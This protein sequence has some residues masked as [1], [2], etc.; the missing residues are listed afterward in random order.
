MSRQLDLVVVNPGNSKR[1]YQSLSDNLTAIE[2][3][4]WAGLLA[5]YVRNKGFSVEI[6]D[7]NA[8]QLT[9]EETAVRVQDMDPVL[10]ALTVYGHNPSAST[11]VMPGA[12][13]LGTT[14]RELAPEMKTIMV[15]GHVAALPERTMREEDVDYVCSGEGL[16]TVVDLLETLKSSV[17]TLKNVRGLWYRDGD[18]LLKTL[19]APLIRNLD[20]EIPAMTWDLLPMDLYRAHNWHGFGDLNRMPYAALYTSLGCPYRCSFCCI[21]A[22]FKQGEQTLGYKPEVNSYRCWSPDAIMAQIDTLVNEYGVRNI[23]IADEM[24]VLNPRHVIG[25]CDGII[26]RGYDLNIWAYT[27]VDTVQDRMI[28]KLS[29]AGVNWLAFGI[30]AASEKVRNDVDKRF[31]EEQIHETLARVR[32][33]DI[34]IGANYIFGLPEDDM[35][36]MQ[37]TL[38]LALEINAEWAN[39]YC[40]MAYPGSQLYD[41]ALRDGMSLPETWAGYSQH[42][43]DSLPLPT[44]H[45]SG[46]DVLRFRDEA[47]NTYFTNSNYLA[48]IEKKFGA[49]TVT[50]INK[51]TAHKL[52]RW[53]NHQT[54]PLVG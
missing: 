28:D 45:L 7:A 24:F 10:T 8:E 49:D 30:E 18:E 39:L 40:A 52:D 46:E 54:L 33:A 3:P 50:H 35:D 29:N 14:L 43:F 47:F 42:A 38:D 19:P 6:I 25:I 15:G 20:E 26:E 53:Y 13:A 23:K 9:I 44:R 32:A 27:R 11:Q 22:P 34:N 31:T 12:S 4:V 36:S 48:M 2:P 1:I 41:D 37:E 16:S 5:A 17:P 21:Q 51:M